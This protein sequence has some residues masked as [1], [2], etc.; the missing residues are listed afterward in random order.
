MGAWGT[1]LYANDT[2]CDIRGEY[3]DK[4]RRGLSNEEIT[5]KLI[6]Q[7]VDCGSDEDDEALFWFALADTQWNHG[8][9]LPFVNEKAMHFLFA[10]GDQRWAEQGPKKTEAWRETL[11]KL[12]DKL[13]SPVPP[14]KRV[15]PY[16]LF[17]CP[18][19]IGDV[20]AYC[21]S[22]SESEANGYTGKYLVFRK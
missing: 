8:R 6:E 18:W 9:L 14:E 13:D 3:L 19:K 4:L 16:R 2:A 7:N 10:E 22:G 20:F 11:R 17:Q 15:S 21:L 5:A 1:S 12:K